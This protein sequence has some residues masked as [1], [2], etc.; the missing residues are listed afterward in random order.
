M[1]GAPVVVDTY[2]T[3]LIQLLES[4]EVEKVLL[5]I[6]LFRLRIMKY[7]VQIVHISGKNNEAADAFSR[8]PAEAMQENILELEIEVFFKH[9][10]IIYEGI[11]RWNYLSKSQEEYITIHMVRE[12]IFNKWKRKESTTKG[13]RSILL[14]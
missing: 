6:Q 8:Y 3:P 5:R 12:K 11:H 2:H 10:T 14:N 7:N 9:N 4:K 1:C 13:F